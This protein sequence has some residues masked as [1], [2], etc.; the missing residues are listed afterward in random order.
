[1]KNLLKPA[2]SMLICGLIFLTG[3]GINSTSLPNE[4]K[5][6]NTD[7]PDT[8]NISRL[9]SLRIITVKRFASEQ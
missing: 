3:C 6:G 1:M 4:L 9:I 7:C 5:A 8:V 2:V